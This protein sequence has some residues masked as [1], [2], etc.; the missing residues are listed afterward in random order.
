ML[1]PSVDPPTESDAQLQDA[2]ASGCIG[3]QR[4]PHCAGTGVRR[5]PAFI[6]GGSWPQPNTTLMPRFVTLTAEVDF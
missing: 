2:H 1:P 3:V 5:H 6:P 4:P